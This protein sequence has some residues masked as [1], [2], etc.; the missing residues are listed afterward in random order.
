MRTC[1]LL[2]GGRPRL[3]RAEEH[4]PHDQGRSA[5]HLRECLGA[6]SP[7]LPAPGRVQMS[8]NCALEDFSRLNIFTNT[9]FSLLVSA[10]SF[11]SPS[12]QFFLPPVA[13]LSFF[14]QL[15][16]LETILTQ[17]TNFL[18]VNFYTFNL[19]KYLLYS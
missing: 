4:C 11:L 2:Q 9:D 5:L 14:F 16:P 17:N 1:P 8:R 13:L 10:G 19:N 3:P 6:S 12:L 18:V 15:L 7:W